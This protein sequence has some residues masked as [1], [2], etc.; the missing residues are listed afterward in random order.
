MAQADPTWRV[1]GGAG[2]AADLETATVEVAVEW[3]WQGSLASG[4]HSWAYVEGGPEVDVV[5]AL[6]FGAGGRGA[7][8]AAPGL[9]STLDVGVR[10]RLQPPATMA[11]R[12]RHHLAP[13]RGADAP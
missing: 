1:G 4:G 9:T 3:A 11:V 8:S 13:A 10:V 6:G 5:E 12:S 2:V 7:V